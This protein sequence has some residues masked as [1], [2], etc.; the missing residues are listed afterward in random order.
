MKE[1][2]Q[3]DFRDVLKT[4]IEEIAA[5]PATLYFPAFIVAQ[6]NVICDE[7]RATPEQL[8]GE[9]LANQIDRWNEFYQY[10]TT[11]LNSP[12]SRFFSAGGSPLLLSVCHSCPIHKQ[13][14]AKCSRSHRIRAT[15]V[16]CAAQVVIQSFQ[17]SDDPADW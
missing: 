2:D 8:V 1:P 9:A 14:Q 10:V 16:A 11:R 15:E 7:Q 5:I 13:L 17:G 4:K 6:L 12:Q 3:P